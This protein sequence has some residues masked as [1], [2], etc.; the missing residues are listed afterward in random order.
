MEI[1]LVI[2]CHNEESNLDRLV[3]DLRPVLRDL[4]P[5]DDVEVVLV[6]DGSTD[7]TWQGLTALAHNDSLGCAVRLER[8]EKNRGLGAALRTGFA[9]SRGRVIITTDSDGTYR[10]SEIP[11]LIAR[12]TADVGIVTASPYHPQGGVANVP[13]YRL[14]L[15]RG[16]SLIYRAL[17]DRKIYTYTAL[18]R[19]YRRDVIKSIAF[20]SDGFL[21]VAELLVN[22]KLAGY[23]VVEHPAVLHSR[24]AGTSKAR[25]VRTIVA[26]VRFQLNVLMRRMGLARRRLRPSRSDATLEVAQRR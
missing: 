6:D 24:V 10:F 26:H 4:G 17:V 15:S 5:L 21:A 13:A 20:T 3:T 12:M 22:A 9:A 18:F 1:S 8:H 11:K 16:S 19:A 23:R 14:V 7:S 2:P 25:L